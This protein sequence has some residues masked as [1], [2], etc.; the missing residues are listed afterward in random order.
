M[1]FAVIIAIAA[2]VIIGVSAFV[3]LRD[4]EDDLLIDDPTPTAVE[5][6]LAAPPPVAEA[7]PVVFALLSLIWRMRSCISCCR[8]K[9]S[10]ASCSRE[11]VVTVS[12]GT[13]G[14]LCRYK[15]GGTEGCDWVTGGCHSSGGP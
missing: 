12:R 6:G 1:L 9:T 4:R 2:V 3:L 10:S 7:P 13:G 11:W 15:G 5:P 8:F 14:G